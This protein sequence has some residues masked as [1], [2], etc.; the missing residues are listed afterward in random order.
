VTDI[1]WAMIRT[2]M[3]S[4]ADTVIFPLQDLLGVGTEGRMNLPGTSSGNWHW[5]YR[6]E[7]LSLGTGARLRQM[8]ET[9][10]R[11]P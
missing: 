8:A 3:A 4:V 5:R 11:L 10:D 7:E 1:N 2:L 9:Y 6:A